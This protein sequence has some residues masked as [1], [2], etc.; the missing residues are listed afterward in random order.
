MAYANNKFNI[1]RHTQDTVPSEASIVVSNNSLSAALSNSSTSSNNRA[2]LF[3]K[4]LEKAACGVGFIV[5]I[6]GVASH[7]VSCQHTIRQAYR[8]I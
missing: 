4:T 6:N 2:S 7:K 5:N 3:N 8:A 1:K